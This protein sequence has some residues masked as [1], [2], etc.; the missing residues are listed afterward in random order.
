MKNLGLILVAILFLYTLGKKQDKVDT[1]LKLEELVMIQKSDSAMNNS[2]KDNIFLKYKLE[3]K[4]DSL[5]YEIQ[6]IA[7]SI[8]LNDNL[9]K[10][11]R[12][13]HLESTKVMLLKEIN[14]LT[15]STNKAWENYETKTQNLLKGT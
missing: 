15:E 9:K 8:A 10:D 5:N 11:S 6:N 1:G 12:Q 3:N 4:L 7:D 13:E 2:I 14:K